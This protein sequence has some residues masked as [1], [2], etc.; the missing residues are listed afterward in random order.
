MRTKLVFLKRLNLSF[1]LI[2][3]AI[4]FIFLLFSWFVSNP[5]RAAKVDRFILYGID[6]IFRFC[7]VQLA[8]QNFSIFLNPYLKP[9]YTIIA[10]IFFRLI[11][12]G[13]MS[14][15]I[16]NSF[17]SVGTL[18]I[19][20]KLLKKLEFDDFFSIFAVLITASIPLYFLLSISTLS[21]I[22]FCFFLILA[23]YLT[24]SEKYLLSV[25]TV[26]LLP[27]IRQ[28][29]LL[30]LLIWVGLLFVRRK[31]R[32][33]PLLFIP[34]LT[35]AFLNY[36]ILDFPLSFTFGYVTS[37]VEPPHD[38]F[39]PGPIKFMLNLGYFSLI[40]FLIG[41]MRRL[42]DKKYYLL[43]AC[44]LIPFSFQVL[45]S[46][47]IYSYIDNKFPGYPPRLMVPSAP[48]I[49]IFIVNGITL[50][51][52]KFTEKKY[53]FKCFLTMVIL[54]LLLSSIY[55]IRQLQCLPDS[56]NAIFSP[57]QERVL[58]EA[59]T[60]FNSYAKKKNIKNLYVPAVETIH[61]S[62]RRLWMGLEKDINYYP[63]V[64]MEDSFYV[65]FNLT[66][67]QLDPK[68]KIE[69]GLLKTFNNAEFSQKPE[70]K[71]IKEFPEIPLYIF[72][73]KEKNAELKEKREITYLTASIKAQDEVRSDEKLLAAVNLLEKGLQTYSE[74][75]FLEALSTFE[76][77][78]KETPNNFLYYYYL[79]RAY[80]TIM[81]EHLFIKRYDRAKEY[82]TKAIEAF[83]ESIELNE[84]F[85]ESHS[86][87]GVV[88]G[89]RTG[90]EGLGE[91]ILNLVR[92]NR[93]THKAVLMMD[94]T[95][96]IAQFNRGVIYFATPWIL[97]GNRGK[98]IK[99][100]KK[101]IKTTPNFIDA[102]LWLNYTLSNKFPKDEDA[103]L[104]RF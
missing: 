33:I 6:D 69:K 91:I 71:P 64:E 58:K 101:A 80:K 2:L 96:P 67:F 26:S 41:L 28:E 39:P 56:M 61:K 77:L 35:W 66:T 92:A 30:Y 49:A 97:G 18:F 43:L 78:I 34:A 75:I 63:L 40:L 57:N 16:M 99:C 45:S 32:Y 38:L 37:I 76:Q 102:H 54:T 20:Y 1:L 74:K 104:D 47:I 51:T 5:I 93:Y 103:F 100:F 86:Y 62:L 15:R 23:I 19:L 53:I 73:I 70:C 48:L 31:F 22:I 11:P 88:Y 95:N 81:D 14:L 44:F 36:L 94:S 29:G 79:G 68:I 50:I 98:A 65:V 42:F 72:T 60:W 10:T 52:R 21:E 13:M 55:Q 3:G 7:L 59:I 9:L 83:K 27:I 84:G 4:L 46:I 24:Y 8:P 17:F 12:L 25:I 89:R 90:R 85:T 82:K 87:L